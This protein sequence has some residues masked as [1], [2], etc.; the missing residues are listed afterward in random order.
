[1]ALTGLTVPRQPWRKGSSHGDLWTLLLTLKMYPMWMITD[2]YNTISPRGVLTCRV[3]GL[4]HEDGWA[5]CHGSWDRGCLVATSVSL[6]LPAC[7]RLCHRVVFDLEGD[8]TTHL[9]GGQLL[10]LWTCTRHCGYYLSCCFSFFGCFSP[11]LVWV[12]STDFIAIMETILAKIV[13]H[14]KD[15]GMTR[16]RSTEQPRTDDVIVYVGY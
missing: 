14:N 2:V 15:N 13:L 1:M 12:S 5:G 8:L 4:R 7:R 9:V 6:S 10:R 11:T 16:T 3:R